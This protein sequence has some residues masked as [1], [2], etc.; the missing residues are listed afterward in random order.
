MKRS[1][2]ALALAACL[3]A[4]APARAQTAQ[5]CRGVEIRPGNDT[6]VICSRSFGFSGTCGQRQPQYPYPGWQDVAFA[7]EPWEDGPITIRAVALDV[8]VVGKGPLLLG[9]FAG[10]NFNPDPM[11][12]YRYFDSAGS[13]VDGHAESPQWPG[14][15]GMQLP[16]ASAKQSFNSPDDPHIDAHVNCTSDASYAGYLFVWYTKP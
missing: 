11:T 2:A 15:A 9:M 16:A 13:A 8:R 12:P 5:S 7:T 1:I 10:N 6:R 3:F 4:V 14:N